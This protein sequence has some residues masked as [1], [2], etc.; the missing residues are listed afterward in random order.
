MTCI[1]A[2]KQDG[3]VY[4]AGDSA[5]V[6]GHDIRTR[7]DP[8]VFVNQGMAYG[9]TTSFRMGQILMNFNRP[10]HAI[11]ST[12]PISDY[13]YLT[14]LFMDAIIKEFRDKG[15]AKEKD[16]QISG[17]NFL[18]GYHGEIYEICDDFQV[19]IVDSD[20]ACVGCGENYA[21]GAMEALEKQTHLI[22]DPQR[23]LEEALDIVNLYSAGV[24]PPFN[25]VSI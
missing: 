17:G 13:Q 18:I 6:A 4:M 7:K 12:E 5:G 10:K 2:Y 19:G 9:F 8:K 3:K 23:L 1:I 16:S 14:G 20:F 25:I 21:Y 11:D 24:C 22:N 15:Y